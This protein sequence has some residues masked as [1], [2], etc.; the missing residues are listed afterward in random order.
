M[1]EI[2]TPNASGDTT[3]AWNPDV[4]AEVSA[5]HKLFDSLREEGYFAYELGENG[6][7][8]FVIYE[9]KPEA[10]TIVM[11]LPMKGG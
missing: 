4:D 9:F 5:A 2:V 6:E 3:I 8:G 10:R 7:K 11:A 1:G